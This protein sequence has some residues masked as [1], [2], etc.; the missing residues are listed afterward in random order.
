[1]QNEFKK[2]SK[3]PINS[4]NKS[5][6]SF[7]LAIL[8]PAIFLL[9]VIVGLSI[10]ITD[11]SRLAT[12]DILV[13]PVS[14]EITINGQTYKNGSHKLEPGTYTAEIKKPDFITKTFTLTLVSG[15]TTNL[16]TYL[17][18]TDGSL[19][20][21]LSHNDDAILATQIGDEEADQ[22]ME[23]AAKSYPI[24]NILP[25]IIDEYDAEYN[26]TNYRIDGGNEDRCTH[27][28]C[29]IITD[30]TGGNEENAKTQITNRGYDLNDYEII[31][32]YEPIEPLE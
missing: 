24:L 2:S 1:M 12:L 23:N 30:T 17:N 10:F 9:L 20:W 3:Y 29:L 5:K 6:N 14:S 18:Q 7:L 8:L 27:D 31:Y 11:Q 32:H 22:L 16:H 4:Q 26:Y 13:S 15:K 21:Y 25:I 19:S 28:F